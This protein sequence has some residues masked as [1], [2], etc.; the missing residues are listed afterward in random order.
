MSLASETMI[1]SN[2][3]SE[4]DNS[5]SVYWVPR[6]DEATGHGIWIETSPEVK[7]MG[8]SRYHL[9][10]PHSGA[11]I[12]ALHFTNTKGWGF[13][14]TDESGDTYSCPTVW[15]RTHYIEYYSKQ[16]IIVKVFDKPGIEAKLNPLYWGK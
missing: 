16:P 6:P 8:I 12:D 15:N 2:G 4:G 14:F 1:L 13:S 11:S 5:A 7:S 10:Q 9:N 3:L